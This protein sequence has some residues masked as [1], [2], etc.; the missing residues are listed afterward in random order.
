MIMLAMML[1][2]LLTLTQELVLGISKKLTF[3]LIFM[4]HMCHMRLEW[5]LV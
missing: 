1:D 4:A 3:P 2:I 5:E